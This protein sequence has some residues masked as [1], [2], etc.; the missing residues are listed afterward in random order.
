MARCLERVRTR[1][2]ATAAELANDIDRQDIVSVNLQRAVQLA[3]DVAAHLL[4]SRD[5]PPADSMGGAFTALAQEDVIEPEL[6][7]VF[8]RAVGF[9]N[10]AV[11]AYQAL[12]WEIVFEIATERLG[13]FER[14][15]AAALRAVDAEA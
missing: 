3:A 13:D 5:R 9:R 2:P 1:V 4:A 15:A 6:A 7:T 11:H 14:F 8:R 12:D 10:I